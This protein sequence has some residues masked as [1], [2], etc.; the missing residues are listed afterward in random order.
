MTM[1]ETERLTLRPWRMDDAADAQALFTYASSPDVGPAAGW[2]PL[3]IPFDAYRTEESAD[4][5]R[6][7]LSAPE[8]YA[9][10]LKRTD[11][12]I[13]SIGLQKPCA[14]VIGTPGYQTPALEIGYWIG[15]PYWGQGLI[16]E[17]SRALMR[18]GFEDLDLQAIWGTHDVENV[19]SS[20]VMDKL[21]LRLVRVQPHV[22]MELLGDVWRD[23]AVRCITR[24]EWEAEIRTR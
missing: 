8:T 23:E 4:I 18:H 6:A 5:I 15:K 21:G 12:P 14:S 1:L 13:G 3:G 9:V 16:P 2:Q 20:R 24:E 10:V 22:H 17:A 7:V 11:E 19:K